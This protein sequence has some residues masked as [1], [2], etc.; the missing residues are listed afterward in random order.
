MTQSAD[1]APVESAGFTL[2]E[3]IVV[4]LIIGVISTLAVS[5]LES[6]TGWRQKS[7]VRA[8]TS[9]WEFLFAE[10]L[11]RRESYRLV[12]NLDDRTYYVRREVKLDRDAVRQVD[13]LKNLRTRSEKERRSK[14]AAEDTLSLEEEFSS[15]DERRNAPLE[16]SYFNALFS[17]PHEEKRL[18]VPV[19]FPALAQTKAFPPGLRIRDLQTAGGNIAA[20]EVQFR[21]SPNANSEPVL[22]HFEVDG[23][24][25]FS[26][27]VSP[28]MGT[29]KIVSGDID[30]RRETG[31]GSADG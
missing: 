14:A 12:L 2:V 15:E 23:G 9:L 7:E 3:L 24:G 18:A 22:I 17:D 21:F 11:A 10:S 27:I 30:F 8:F 16:L 26:V 25:I 28:A 4:V 5:R 29:A 31:R 19:E 20:G 13:Y 6:L 1:R